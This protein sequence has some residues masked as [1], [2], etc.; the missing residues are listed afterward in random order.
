MTQVTHV[1]FT[2][3]KT[4][5]LR[6]CKEKRMILELKSVLRCRQDNEKRSPVDRRNESGIR[7]FWREGL[8]SRYI[9]EARGS[10]GEHGRG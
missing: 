3:T 7:E 9:G 2:K 4:R 10:H 6:R 1:P 8:G 5:S